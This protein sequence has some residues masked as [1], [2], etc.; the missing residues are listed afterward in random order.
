[1]TPLQ[2]LFGSVGGLLPGLAP[3]LLGAWF[4]VV[5]AAAIRLAVDAYRGAHRS[6]LSELPFVLGTGAM[7]TIFFILSEAR[8]TGLIAQDSWAG[9]L[10]GSLAVSVSFVR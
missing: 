5:V 1:M 2:H 4:F 7:L 9:W 10:I 6:M 3:W 8:H